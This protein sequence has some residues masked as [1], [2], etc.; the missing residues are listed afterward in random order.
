[1]RKCISIIYATQSLVLCYGI[2]S[3]IVQGHRGLEA[4]ISKQDHN[5]RKKK[6]GGLQPRLDGRQ[7]HVMNTRNS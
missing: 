7:H 6:K 4:K 1:M 2:V 5:L 3:R